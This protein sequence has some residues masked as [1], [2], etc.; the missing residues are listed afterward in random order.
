MVECGMTRG[1][2]LTPEQ[3][4]AIADAYLCGDRLKVIARRYGIEQNTINR[5]R[6][7]LGISPRSRWGE[8]Q[9]RND[10]QA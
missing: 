9:S 8:G 6:K 5:I 7:R 4:R 3:L 1:K 10:R 2:A